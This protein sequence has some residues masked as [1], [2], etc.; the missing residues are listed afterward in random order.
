MEKP[1]KMDDLGVPLFSE[2]S[3]S[4]SREL[5]NTV[6]VMFAQRRELPCQF[7]ELPY[8]TMHFPDVFNP[9]KLHVRQANE[10]AQAQAWPLSVRNIFLHALCS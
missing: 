8:I 9:S 10:S 7:E 3:V 4:R 5:A 2:T 6:S 1:N